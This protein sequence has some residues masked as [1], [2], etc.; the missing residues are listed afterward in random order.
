MKI[1]I[2]AYLEAGAEQPDIAIEQVQQALDASGHDTSLLL[3]HD[4]VAEILA[5]LRQEVLDDEVLEAHPDL[6]EHGERGE[7]REAHRDHRNR[8]EQEVVAHRRRA[9]ET[10]VV[11]VALGDVPEEQRDLAQ[12]PDHPLHEDGGAR[13]TVGR[14]V[15]G[16]NLMRGGAPV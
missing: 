9:L 6:V 13:G 16:G 1:T 10:V 4:D 7:D 8:G 14:R 2:L 15:H 3:V 12:A 5:G 11:P